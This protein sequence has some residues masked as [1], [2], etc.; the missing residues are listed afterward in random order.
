MI[1][2]QKTHAHSD[3]IWPENWEKKTL[4]FSVCNEIHQ[5]YWYFWDANIHNFE[6]LT[7]I[8][9]PEEMKQ[10]AIKNK[11]LVRWFWCMC[12]VDAIKNKTQKQNRRRRSS[13]KQKNAL[14]DVWTLVKI[15]YR[16]LILIK[17]SGKKQINRNFYEWQMMICTES[18]H[19]ASVKELVILRDKSMRSNGDC[20]ICLSLFS[21]H[22]FLLLLFFL[23][24]FSVVPYV[25]IL[26]SFEKWN[27][28]AHTRQMDKWMNGIGSPAK[29]EEERMG[30]Q[31]SSSQSQTHLM[32]NV[33][34]C[35]FGRCCCCRW[36]LRMRAPSIPLTHISLF[37]NL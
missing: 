27:S 10:K 37:S 22:L 12:G 13:R 18:T 33:C 1:E 7:L 6:T 31:M 36:L 32:P 8:L 11:L 16:T 26:I 28:R 34:F 4:F 2:K 15:L 29:E 30:K 23:V 5:T 25:F 24:R 9:I 20:S 3:T 17:R 21:L 35:F 14:Q 19:T